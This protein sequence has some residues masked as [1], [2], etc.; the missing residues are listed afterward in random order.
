M[1]ITCSPC[2]PKRSYH[3]GNAISSI[4]ADLVY[5]Y[6]R[7]Y[8]SCEIY[9]V[10]NTPWNVHGLPYANIFQETYHRN[11]SYEEILDLANEQIAFACR[12]TSCFLQRDQC[13][14]DCCD[15]D[16]D[17]VAYTKECF[18]KLIE[19]G[20]L[21][22]RENVWYIDTA[23]FLQ[24]YD[25]NEIFSDIQ[26]VPTYHKPA[27]VKQQ[28]TFN[29]LY[30][31]SKA[32]SFTVSFEYQRQQIDVNPIFQSFIYLNWLMVRFQQP[33]VDYLVG[34]SG[35]S[36]LKWQYYRQ[37][38]STALVH[39]VSVHTLLLHGTI[40]GEDL[41]P[42][43]K[44]STNCIQPS[45]LYALS[46]DSNLVRYILIRSLSVNNLKIQQDKFL[47]EYRRIQNLLPAISTGLRFPEL[48]SSVSELDLAL[49]YIQQYKFSLA[50]ETFYLYLRRTVFLPQG[51]FEAFQKVQKLYNIFFNSATPHPRAGGNFLPAG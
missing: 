30:P 34:G 31:I 26:C 13:T 16:K 41:K 22:N 23:A 32:R 39:D 35:F 11:G 7:E 9:H 10:I 38:I 28:N 44:H 18:I 19:N 37:I 47:K 8:D 42:M 4:Y 46:S 6:H 12:E 25:L 1:I 24:K 48:G 51:D 33:I 40:L 17:F 14:A 45:Q 36:M 20:M 2:M 29:D 49:F 50:L 15:A 3:C 27:I 21:V 5:R 43:S